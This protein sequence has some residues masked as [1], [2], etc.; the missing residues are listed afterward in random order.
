[1]MKNF[2][3]CVALM[4]IAEGIF[5]CNSHVCVLLVPIHRIELVDEIFYSKMIFHLVF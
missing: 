1:M 2:L 3:I 5:I 4:A